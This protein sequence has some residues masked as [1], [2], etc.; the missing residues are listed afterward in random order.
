M[1]AIYLILILLVLSLISSFLFILQH[2]RNSQEVYQTLIEDFKFQTPETN[3]LIKNNFLYLKIGTGV[4]FIGMALILSISLQNKFIALGVL[5]CSAIILLGR[6]Y[7]NAIQQERINL[8][9]QQ[10]LPLL[11]ER[12]VMTIESGHDVVSGLKLI[13]SNESSRKSSNCP[14]IKIF[15]RAIDYTEQGFTF[16]ESLREISKNC[17]VISVKHVLI[18][19]ALAYE[20]GGELIIPLRELSDATQIQYQELVDERIAKLPVKATFPLLLLFA[21]LI[22]LFVTPP[23]LEVLKL[24]TGGKL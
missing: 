15:G 18:H 9:F 11:L 7:Y 17:P 22:I 21:G 1:L 20:Q 2:R 14:L 10:S 16:T 13:V 23:I 3:K 4:V 8:S 19:L 5:F 6:K 24:T 12:L